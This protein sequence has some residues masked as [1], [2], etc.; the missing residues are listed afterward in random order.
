MK[1]NEC[2]FCDKKI[3]WYQPK[4]IVLVRHK[5]NRY[6]EYRM[7]KKCWRVVNGKR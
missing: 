7:H 1:K 4:V 5:S 6:S 3:K 2:Y